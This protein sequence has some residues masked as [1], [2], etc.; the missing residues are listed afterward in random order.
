MVPFSQLGTVLK[1]TQKYFLNHLVL[2]KLKKALIYS[3]E[4]KNAWQAKKA[5]SQAN[6]WQFRYFLD[7][8]L[9]SE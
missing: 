9:S 4:P 7:N 6:P 5:S 8:F 1:I 2:Q 3:Q